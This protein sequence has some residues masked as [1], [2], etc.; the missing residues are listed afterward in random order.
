MQPMLCADGES[1]SG[2]LCLRVSGQ[3]GGRCESSKVTGF[4]GNW[5][6]LVCWPRWALL[7]TSDPMDCLPCVRHWLIRQERSHPQLSHSPGWPWAR[8]VK[9]SALR[10]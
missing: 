8:V 1:W 6:R 2:W 9:M 7:P 5:E 10:V 4:K 3:T